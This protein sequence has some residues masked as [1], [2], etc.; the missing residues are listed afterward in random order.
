MKV[1]GVHPIEGHDIPGVRS[2][3][4]LKQTALFVPN[5]Y[6]G[7]V[8]VSNDE[9]FQLCKRINQEESIIAGPSSGMALAGAL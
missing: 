8:D 2:I 5:E 1:L 3:R 7:L 9:A 4:Q 6:D